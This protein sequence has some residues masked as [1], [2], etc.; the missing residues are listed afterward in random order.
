MTTI[1]FDTLSV[2]KRL[3]KAGF[4]AQQAEA[5]TAIV[6]E[7]SDVEARQLVTKKDLQIELAPLRTDLALLKWMAGVNSAMILGVL[8]KLFL[9]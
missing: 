7:A 1:T 4:T 8:L 6:S 9:N 3:Q 5:M 2:A